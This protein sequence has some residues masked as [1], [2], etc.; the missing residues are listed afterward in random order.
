MSVLTVTTDLILMIPT[1]S[2]QY[3]W[4][5]KLTMSRPQKQGYKKRP[6]RKH[7]VLSE[8]EIEAMEGSIKESFGT[9]TTEASN[10]PDKLG[11]DERD[12]NSSPY[13]KKKGTEEHQESKK[14]PEGEGG[15]RKNYGGKTPRGINENDR[16]QRFVWTSH[17]DNVESSLRGLNS[18]VAI[19]KTTPSHTPDGKLFLPT[20]VEERV[21]RLKASVLSMTDEVESVFS[22]D[23]VGLLSTKTEYLSSTVKEMERVIKGKNNIV[24]GEGLRELLEKMIDAK[25]EYQK[26]IEKC[27]LFE[28]GEMRQ[29]QVQKRLKALE[30]KVFEK[31]G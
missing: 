12:V 25:Y 24:D 11:I 21:S 14:S 15:T 22:N 4:E 29:I 8:R 10:H 5:R 16:Q 17:L 27:K 6:I 7:P 9:K 23:A 3:Y 31:E 2:P 19:A 18:L 28:S 20:D 26:L 30:D 13:A 1:V